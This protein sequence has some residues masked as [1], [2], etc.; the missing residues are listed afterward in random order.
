M[1]G[2]AGCA[3][4]DSRW[5]EPRAAASPGAS[6]AAPGGAPRWSDCSDIAEKLLGSVPRNIRYDC[7]TITVPQDWTPATAG[8][9][10]DGKTFDISLLRARSSRQ[11]DRIG[12]LMSNP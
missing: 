6:T 4:A 10:A 3:G 1:V 11:T 8:V 9:A 7:A 5:V 2:V 12:S